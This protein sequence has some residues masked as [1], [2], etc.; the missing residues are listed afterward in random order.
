LPKCAPAKLADLQRRQK[1]LQ[2]IAKL[3][4]K[5]LTSE[6]ADPLGSRQGG[7]RMEEHA[8]ADIVRFDRFQLDRRRGVLSR[9]N[10]DGGFTPLAIGSR[11]LDILRLLIDR[12]GDLVSRDEILNTVWPGVVEGANVTVQISALRHVLDE[13]RSGPSLIQTVPGRGYRLVAAVTAGAANAD[14]ADTSASDSSPAP[15]LSEP[16]P[17]GTDNRG[18]SAPSAAEKPSIAV[19]PFQNISP[20]PDQEFLADGIAEDIVTALSRYPS[21]FVIARNSCFTY[22]GRNVDVKQVGRELGVRYVLEGSLRKA[23][24]RIRVTAQ[25][26]EAETANHIWADRYD[27]ICQMS[28]RFKRR[29]PR[30]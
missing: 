30:R 29:F 9:Q 20:D 26:V 25:L 12:N 11:G 16:A 13:G 10:Q 19:L 1:K 2:K 28:S 7:G 22:K 8:G 6:I 4:V 18:F 5:G 24:N 27:R 23:G 14:A 21:L 15:R 17:L 3:Q